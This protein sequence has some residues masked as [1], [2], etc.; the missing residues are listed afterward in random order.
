VRLLLDAHISARRIGQA[1]RSRGHDVRA[2]D[3][4]R[5][6]DAWSDEELLSLAAAGGRILVTFNVRDFARLSTEWAEAGRSHAGCA[7]LVGLDHREFGLVVRR[8]E[9]AFAHRP[10]QRDW[11]DRADYIGRRS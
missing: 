9:A 11:C 10:R 1:L 7:L 2:A 6:L 4:E 5:A 8:L 3:E